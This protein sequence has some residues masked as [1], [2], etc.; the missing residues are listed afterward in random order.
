[1]GEW[2]GGWVR[3]WVVGGGRWGWVGGWVSDKSIN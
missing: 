2:V 1:M 3:E